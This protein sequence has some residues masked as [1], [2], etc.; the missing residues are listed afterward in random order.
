ME[1]R[2]YGLCLPAPVVLPF[3]CCNRNMISFSHDFKN[4]SVFPGGQ[5]SVVGRQDK[6]LVFGSL[7]YMNM[8][9]RGRLQTGISVNVRPRVGSYLLT[10]HEYAPEGVAPTSSDAVTILASDRGVKGVGGL[11]V[12]MVLMIGVGSLCPKRPKRCCRWVRSIV[13]VR[14]G[15]I[16]IEFLGCGIARLRRYKGDSLEVM[17]AVYLQART[18]L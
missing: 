7:R 9:R 14:S 2:E 1:E 16:A 13:A 4:R 12:L 17:K 6:L 5:G 15:G 18:K 8:R 3:P 10:R 11:L